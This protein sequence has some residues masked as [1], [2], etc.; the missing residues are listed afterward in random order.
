MQTRINWVQETFTTK[1]YKTP[2]ISVKVALCTK[3]GFDFLKSQGVDVYASKIINDKLIENLFSSNKDHYIE[4][5]Q[6]LESKLLT[7]Y[8]TKKNI[9]KLLP[10]LGY[11]KAQVALSI[12][13]M[14]TPNNVFPIFWWQYAN[15]AEEREVLLLRDMEDA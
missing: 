13:T 5:M 4:M 10:S 7:V 14:N 3:S 15:N 9:T 12:E 1:N 6:Y 11:G 8:K 2:N